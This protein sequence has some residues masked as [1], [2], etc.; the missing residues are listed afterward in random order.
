MF[1]VSQ[2]CQG[3]SSWR[4]TSHAALALCEQ[5]ERPYIVES[6]GQVFNA[7]GAAFYCSVSPVRLRLVTTRPCNSGTALGQSQFLPIVFKR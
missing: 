5:L 4:P 1:S 2:A 6:L 7:E 3:E